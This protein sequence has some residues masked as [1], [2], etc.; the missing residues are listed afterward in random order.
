MQGFLSPIVQKIANSE[1]PNELKTMQMKIFQLLPEVHQLTQ[2]HLRKLSDSTAQDHYYQ[3]WISIFRD[4]ETT[5]LDKLTYFFM[6]P[7][8][9]LVQQS[10][11]DLKASISQDWLEALVKHYCLRNRMMHN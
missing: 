10:L 9:E 1:D 5:L 4:L 6:L 2:S 11:L 3:L 7:N 8:Q